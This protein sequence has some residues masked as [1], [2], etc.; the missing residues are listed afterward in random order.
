MAMSDVAYP[1]RT[2]LREVIVVF[3][4]QLALVATLVHSDDYLQLGGNLH[5]LVGVVFI[6]LPIL[7][8][9]RR[10]KPYRRY[11]FTVEQVH[12]DIFW[13]LLLGALLFPP[14]AL[15]APVVWGVPETTWSFV[16]PEEYPS[17]A[18][19]H[20]IAVALPEEV[21]YRGYIMGRFDDIFRG[22]ISLLGA[23]VGWALPLQAALFAAGH[24]F[25]DFNP[26]RLA[27][28]FPALSFG[29]L[30]AKRGT[31][32]AGVLFHAMSNVFMDLF[33]AGLGL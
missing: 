8:L 17:L 32:G 14:I 11:G 6:L 29:W 30:K 16:W 33:R 19:V 7:V 12:L 31:L 5:M 21:F 9:D 10:G 20:L 26:G 23:K 22:R 18:L 24:Y 15:G 28:F 3:S 25:I 13:A 27:V 1:P 4:V 2:L